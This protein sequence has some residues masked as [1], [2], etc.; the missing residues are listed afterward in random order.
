M[1]LVRQSV[2]PRV[3]EN[4]TTPDYELGYL[5]RRLECPYCRGMYRRSELAALN[6]PG[7]LLDLALDVDRTQRY[8]RQ[9]G[10]VWRTFDGRPLSGETGVDAP[11]FWEEADVVDVSGLTLPGLLP[12]MLGELPR[13]ELS[14]TPTWQGEF[15]FV[16]DAGLRLANGV[17]AYARVIQAQVERMWQGDRQTEQF[18]EEMDVVTRH[19]LQS[20]GERA[21]VA[22]LLIEVQDYVHEVGP[23]CGAAAEL[24]QAVLSAEE[25]EMAGLWETLTGVPCPILAVPDLEPVRNSLGAETSWFGWASAITNCNRVLASVWET[26]AA[27]VEPQA[28]PIETRRMRARTMLA[29]I[30]QTDVGAIACYQYLDSAFAYAYLLRNENEYLHGQMAE[31]RR[32]LGL[33]PVG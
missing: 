11:V 21:A 33:E 9:T 4:L 6:V 1:T 10:D 32:V 23:F 26:V 27:P 29:A 31:A 7:D 13:L 2:V 14:F 3:D 16:R 19:V 8:I 12:D 24:C 25:H 28:D 20:V 17:E 30:M 22:E 5:P 15:G 18:L